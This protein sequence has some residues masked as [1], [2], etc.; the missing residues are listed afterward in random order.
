MKAILNNK[1][2]K[3][4]NSIKR[5]FKSDKP[6]KEESGNQ[7]QQ[8]K[9]NITV[10]INN[11][12]GLSPH[13]EKLK[14]IMQ[15]IQMRL[16]D[17]FLGKEAHISFKHKK[18][19]QYIATQ[20]ISRY[21]ITT[22]ESKWELTHLKKPGGTFVITNK[23]YQYRIR[24]TIKDEAGRWVGNV[25]VFKNNTMLA[26]ISMYKVGNKA[27]KCSLSNYSQQLTWLQ[28][29]NRNIDPTVAHKQDLVK[30]ATIW[31]QQYTYVI[32]AGDFNEHSYSEGLLYDLQ[33]KV[34]LVPATNNLPQSSYLRG[35]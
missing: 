26:M 17:I 3:S 5:K 1:Q 8:Q 22:S 21:H 25:Y 28:Q 23:K 2:K 14:D 16:C 34:G 7:K 27:I 18:M 35:N 32:I 11:V 19:L 6:N 12:A 31:K 29:Q 10:I 33:S 24:H 30:E 4:E 13:T 9:E 20:W 15:W